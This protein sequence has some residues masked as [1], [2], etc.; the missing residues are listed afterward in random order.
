MTVTRSLALFTSLG[1]L[2]PPAASKTLSSRVPVKLALVVPWPAW[3]ETLTVSA[4]SAFRSSKVNDLGVPTRPLMATSGENVVE[5]TPGTG[6]AAAGAGALAA[7]AAGF[8]AVAGA[9]VVAAAAGCAA[10]VVGA[11]AVG[12]RK[13]HFA[14]VAWPSGPST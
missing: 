10:A 12:G 13:P 11:E 6:A 9:G 14:S 8:A 5:A 4:G 7:A 1:S 3:N 2:A